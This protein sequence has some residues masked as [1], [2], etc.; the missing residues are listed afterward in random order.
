MSGEISDM[1]MYVRCTALL[2]ALA[3]IGVLFLESSAQG[4][5]PAQPPSRQIFP[6][7]APPQPVDPH[8]EKPRVIVLSDIGG[9]P[10][11]QESFVR[12]L[13]YSNEFDIE[14]LVAS[15]RQLHPEMMRDEI[16]AFGQVRTNLMLNAEGWPEVADLLSRV[17]A[18][19]AGGGLANTG[20]GKSTEGSEAILH[21]IESGDPR[22]LWITI[23]GGANTL[24]QALKDFRSAHT[25]EE[26]TRLVSHVRVY[27][28][29]DQ[30]DAGPWIRREFPELVY[31]VNPSN[32]GPE[33]YPYATWTGISGD[34]FF[35]E[36]DEGADFTTVTNE[37][38]D[39]NIRSKGPLGKLYPPYIFI[40]E[41][42]TPSFLGLVNNG[43]NSYRRPDWGGWGGRYNYVRPYGETHPIWARGGVLNLSGVNSQDEVIGTDGKPHVSDQA[44]IW[45]WREA[46]QNDF[47]ARA[48]WMVSD[49][50]HS[51]HNP[52]AIVNGQSG[53][54]VIQMTAE[55]GKPIVLDAGGSSDP[56]GQSIQF[57]W[58][59]YIE[60][61]TSGTRPALVAIEPPPR[62]R[63]PALAVRVSNAL[64]LAPLSGA[65]PASVIVGLPPWE[66]SRVR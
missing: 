41:G 5:A 48:N 13:L 64:L 22:P 25:P 40:M 1:K 26:V 27:S 4:Q 66:L 47:A 31:V 57:H 29:S 65:S 34:R 45:R 23:W 35:R 39:T 46:F 15:S 54:D 11:D 7:Q 12:F 16:N 8:V 30:D 32:P 59:Q 62:L 52:V 61:G 51:N 17:H 14:A 9:D 36:G 42:D 37:W 53:T 6:P 63:Y 10:D 28:I 43:L 24:A 20:E 18:G 56:D 19:Q 38:L 60:A 49:F 44:T 50:A 55:V 33:E 21:A 2:A 3:G 58:F